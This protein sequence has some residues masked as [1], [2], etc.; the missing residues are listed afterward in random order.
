[1]CLLAH[2]LHSMLIFEY[3]STTYHKLMVCAETT[4]VATT[5]LLLGDV[6][7]FAFHTYGRVHPHMT[8]LIQKRLSYCFLLIS[9]LVGFITRVLGEDPL[10]T[11]ILRRKINMCVCCRINSHQINNS[12]TSMLVGRS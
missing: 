3:S 2:K 8:P 1:M 6:V 10:S 11:G 12:C 9:H 7:I 5:I 4:V